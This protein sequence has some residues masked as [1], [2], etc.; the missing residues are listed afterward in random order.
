MGGET[1]ILGSTRNVACPLSVPEDGHFTL[2][3]YVP[4]PA[5]AGAFPTMKDPDTKF[6]AETLAVAEVTTL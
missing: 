6:A 2:I 4:A 1:K 3:V 5:A